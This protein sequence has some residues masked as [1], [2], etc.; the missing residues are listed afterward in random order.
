M[1]D[2]QGQGGSEQTSTNQTGVN[3]IDQP[4]G[5]LAAT[6]R[7]RLLRK[8]LFD[9]KEYQHNNQNRARSNK[10]SVSQADLNRKNVLFL[11][12]VILE[13]PNSNAYKRLVGQNGNER[14]ISKVAITKEILNMLDKESNDELG[15][16]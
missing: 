9:F 2:S 6:E 14:S 11:I 1:M 13:N 4:K 3:G 12:D 7:A 5:D 10:V 16:A 8:Y 15:S